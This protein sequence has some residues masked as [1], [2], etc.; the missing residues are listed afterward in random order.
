MFPRALLATLHVSCIIVLLVTEC[1][2]KLNNQP[3]PHHNNVSFCCETVRPP[4]TFII[5]IPLTDCD[6]FME[7][8]LKV[9][10]FQCLYQT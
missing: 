8:I 1:I 7:N 4:A 5:I 6:L 2:L 9:F 10:T 3:P